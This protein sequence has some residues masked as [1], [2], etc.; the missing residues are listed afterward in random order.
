MVPIKSIIGLAIFACLLAVSAPLKAQ[1]ETPSPAKELEQL[2]QTLESDADRSRL[3]QDLKTLLEAQ[4]APQEPELSNQLIGAVAGQLEQASNRIVDLA[5]ALGRAPAFFE[6]GLQGLSSVQLS[7]SMVSNLLQVLLILSLA[8]GAEFILVLGLKSARRLG[9]G[10]KMPRLTVRLAYLALRTFID[11]LP[12]LVFSG[13]AYLLISLAAEDDGVRKV[14]LHLA[15]AYVNIRTLTILIRAL[16]TPRTPELRVLS[17]SDDHAAYLYVWFR[18]FVLVGVLAFHGMAAA[19]PLGLSAGAYE[20]GLRLISLVLLGMALV[21][22]FQ[23]R[24]VVADW[25]GEEARSQGDQVRPFARL[26]QKIGDIWHVLITGYLIVAYGIWALELPGGFI[27]LA[28]ATLISLGVL[29]LARLFISLMNK[30]AERWLK[31][32]DDLEAK[33][34]GLRDRA[35]RYVPIFGRLAR[36][37]VWVFALLIVFQ[38]WGLDLLTPLSEPAGQRFLN[39]IVSI[40]IIGVLALVVWEV[41]SAA[42]QRYLD[43]QDGEDGQAIRSARIR[44]LLPVLRNAILIV[45]CVL[46]TLVVLSELGINTAPLLAGAGVAGLAIGFGAQKLVQDVINGGFLLVEDALQVGD[47]VTVAGSTG[48]VERLSIRSIRLRD[49]N[50]NVFT[51]PFSNVDTVVNLTKEFS[52]AVMDIG[53]AY[54]E[55]TDVVSAIM[56]EVGAGMQADETWGPLILEPL[57]I[58]GVDQLADSAVI[59]R[60]RFKTQPL[61]QFSIRREY[62]RRIK[63]R[64]DELGIEIPF[65]HTTLYFGED[66][67]GKAPPV[68]VLQVSRKSARKKG[69]GLPEPEQTTAPVDEHVGQN[70][71]PDSSGPPAGAAPSQPDSGG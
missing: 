53:V 8:A 3:V 29:V 41:S 10:A 33:L 42:I 19:L 40:V 63:K 13:V 51:I 59:I 71:I 55:D 18:R 44:T 49:V 26:K 56:S 30:L 1:E 11:L 57:E 5:T 58:L 12:V 39:G 69:E 47:V 66:Q 50:G 46:V 52:F 34:P 2:I 43:G 37:A 67:D 68:Q 6:E 64:F 60:C 38:A 22:V 35:N 15:L 28:R 54:R 27:F 70:A 61:K 25:L 36:G 24:K 4:A 17:L 48:V 31:I 62:N 21:F 23:N 16:L 45:L 65:P 9:A 32:P 20:G 14:A 7:S